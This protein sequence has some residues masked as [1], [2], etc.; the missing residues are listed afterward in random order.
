MSEASISFDRAAEYYDRTRTFSDETDRLET[1]LL[2][3]ELRGRSRILEIGVGT[4]Q[5]AIRLHAAGI[6]MFGV[7]LST[8]MLRKLVEKSAGTPPFPVLAGDATQLPTRSAAFDGVVL[9][10]VFHLVPG[11]RQVVREMVRVVRRGGVVLVN[12]GGTS[13]VGREVRAKVEEIV[14]RALPFPGLYPERWRDLRAEMRACGA[15]HRALEGISDRR[16]E[17]L[18]MHVAGISEG[19]WAWTWPLSGPERA[20]AASGLEAWLE[21]RF[22]RLDIP[23]PHQSTITW[24]AYDLR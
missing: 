12:H 17:P 8:A 11:W 20:A 7:D 19:R 10:H 14:G 15:R 5:V 22:G 6:R 16:D 21:E 18:S 2:V 9:R 23:R 4:G 24:H 13:G 3:A 1:K